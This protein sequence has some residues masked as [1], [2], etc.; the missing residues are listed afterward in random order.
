MY[1]NYIGADRK[2]GLIC[3]IDMRDNAAFR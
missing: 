1:R 3:I 2:K